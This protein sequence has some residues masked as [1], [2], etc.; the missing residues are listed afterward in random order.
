MK[1]LKFLLFVMLA[2]TFA[3]PAVAQSPESYY[4][5]GDKAEH[6]NLYDD[7]FQAYKKAHDLKPSDTK[8]T[9]AYLRLRF[10]AAAEHIKKG[11]ALR[12]ANQLQEALAEYRIAAQ[13]DPSNFEALGEIR[14][15]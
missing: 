7:A 2:G 10:Y 6:K 9:A 8:Y 1:R 4:K 12:D 5:T 13:I 15:A 11:D 3:L 14:R